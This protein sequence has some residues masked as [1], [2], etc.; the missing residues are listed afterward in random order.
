MA[1]VGDLKASTLPCR[2]RRVLRGAPR[3][4]G[5]SSVGSSGELAADV[6]DPKASAL[7]RRGRRA[8]RG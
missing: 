6:G 3:A 4:Q 2:G 7:P 8:S 5:C 1:E